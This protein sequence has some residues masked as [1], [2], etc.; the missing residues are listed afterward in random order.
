M[1]KNEKSPATHRAEKNQSILI[2]SILLSVI[3]ITG[4]VHYFGSPLIWVPITLL[5][6]LMVGLFRNFY[7]KKWT[8]GRN[9]IKFTVFLP[10]LAGIAS[11]LFR[12]EDCD[13]L[14]IILFL[15]LAF[16]SILI[17]IIFIIINKKREKKKE[18]ERSAQLHKELLIRETNERAIRE[19]RAQ[20]ALKNIQSSQIAKWADILAIT[21]LYNANEIS[22]MKDQ[23]LLKIVSAPLHELITIS[24]IK[25]HIIWKNELVL[26]LSLIEKLTSLSY[27]DKILKVQIKKMK[28]FLMLIE[29]KREYTGYNLLLKTIKENCR[30]TLYLAGK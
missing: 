20:Q 8:K 10:I 19:A 26:A 1:K 25:K 16:A 30:E 6:A 13:T 23:M 14:I 4:I 12:I 21:Y 11:A 5:T 2:L 3:M 15:L 29:S 27:D 9:W 18:E 22:E 17:K 7:V 24:D 28:D